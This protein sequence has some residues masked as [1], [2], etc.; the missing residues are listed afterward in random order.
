MLIVS[1]DENVK[2]LVNEI[3]N[4]LTYDEGASILAYIMRWKS[5]V[6]ERSNETVVLII[7]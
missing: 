3:S 5:S 1:I 6:D 2:S 4:G 7:V